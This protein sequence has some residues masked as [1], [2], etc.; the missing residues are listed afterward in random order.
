MRY[1][2][3]TVYRGLYYLQTATPR[4][5]YAGERLPTEPV[6]APPCGVSEHNL[7]TLLPLKLLASVLSLVPIDRAASVLLLLYY[8]L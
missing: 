5:M 3:F 8:C 6:I 2:Q 4:T 1:R 7:N